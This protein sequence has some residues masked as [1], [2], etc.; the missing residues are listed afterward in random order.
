MVLLI[1]LV[2]ILILKMWSRFRSVHGTEQYPME[3]ECEGRTTAKAD[4]HNIGLDENVAYGKSTAV[5]Q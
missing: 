3:N 5:R 2:I 4:E 1:I